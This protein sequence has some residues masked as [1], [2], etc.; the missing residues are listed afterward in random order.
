MVVIAL[1]VAL[2]VWGVGYG[3][4]PLFTQDA[5]P[6]AEDAPTTDQPVEEFAA[7]ADEGPGN[8]PA[9]EDPALPAN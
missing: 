8:D 3:L 2:V 5:T 6:T 7:D 1:A 4:G 9:Q